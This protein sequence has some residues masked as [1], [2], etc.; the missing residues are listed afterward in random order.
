MN[1]S[2][3]TTN[4]HHFN[5]GISPPLNNCLPTETQLKE[6]I[7]FLTLLNELKI[8]DDS[9]SSISIN[10]SKLKIRNQ[11]IL[12]N[13]TQ[14]LNDWANEFLLL[15]TSTVT[16]KTTTKLNSKYQLTRSYS[17]GSYRLGLITDQGDL[18]VLMIGPRYITREDFFKY[19]VPEKLS[20]EN[21]NHISQV[22]PIPNAHIPIVKIVYDN[23]HIDLVYASI[24]YLNF[25]DASFN[26]DDDYHVEQL[27]KHFQDE[28]TA[29]SLNGRRVTD[30]I[31]KVIPNIETFRCS[32][33][34][35]K[36]WAKRRGIYG[37]IHGYLSG[38]SLAILTARVCQLYP[39]SL[40]VTIVKEFFKF[41]SNWKWP[42]PI[43]L[44]HLKHQE[45]RFFNATTDQMPI[46]TCSYPVMNTTHNISK[47]TRDII[48]SEMKRAAGMIIN[49]EEYEQKQGQEQDHIKQKREDQFLEIISPINFFGSYKHY[50]KIQLCVSASDDNHENKNNLETNLKNE[51]EAWTG[52]CE[53]RLRVFVNRL[54][55]DNIISQNKNI[56]VIPWPQKYKYKSNSL[57]SPSNVFLIGLI[58]PSKNEQ[59][60]VDFSSSVEYYKN[61]AASW[62][63]FNKTYKFDLD[64]IHLN[65]KQ[66]TK[67]IINFEINI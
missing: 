22:H 2:I 26:I 37:N 1:Y 4:T 52:W 11:N 17:F 62:P 58:L 27:L 32:L 45:T 40:P 42:T 65:K 5:F 46:L 23:V 10:Q 8:F 21:N 54:L 3:A 9:D 36:T 18:D 35:L 64:I 49:I 14:L 48:L 20:S 28:K 53:S 19:F 67:D 31:L 47:C 7:K 57:S 24:P 41:Y 34:Y 43:I 56:K 38:V 15:K 29:H 25:I 60:F 6:N 16:T 39:N 55:D 63:S 30:G 50:L 59:K 61:L 66:L 33:S 13:L 12:H 44:Q 51:L